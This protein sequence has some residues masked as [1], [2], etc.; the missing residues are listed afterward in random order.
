MWGQS[1]WGNRYWGV[2]HWGHTGANPRD[3]PFVGR[4]RRAVWRRIV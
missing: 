3:L 1:Y 2:S 4:V